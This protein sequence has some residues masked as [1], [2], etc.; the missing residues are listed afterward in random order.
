MPNRMLRDWTDSEKMKNLSAQAERFFTRLIMKADDYG[1]FHA[2]V[3]LLKANL[4]PLLLDAVREADISRWIA[5]C[6]KA[7]LIVLYQSNRKWFLQIKEFRQRLDKSRAKFPLPTGT[8][9]REIV[10]EFRAETETEKEVEKENT[11]PVST[12]V[13]EQD[14]YQSVNKNKRDVFEYIRDHNPTLIHPYVDLWNFFAKERKLAQVSKIT[15]TRIKKFS[16]R[17]HERSFKFLDILSMA[18]QSQFLLTSSWFGFDWIIENESN[19][20]KILEGNYQPKSQELNQQSNANA[21]DE[22]LKKRQ[23]AEARTRELGQG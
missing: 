6:E 21:T 19:Y 11:I 18:S 7:G 8:D 17:I 20:L 5:E 12:G 1:C 9:F 15:S 16:V 3:S 13:S 23:E 4:F 14:L 10:N 22:Y 2:N